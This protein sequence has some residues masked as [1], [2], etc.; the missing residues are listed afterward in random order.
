MN[1]TGLQC[2]GIRPE[3]ELMPAPIRLI[4]ALTPMQESTKTV[5]MSIVF[6]I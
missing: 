5:V 3:D 4:C 6:F 1:Y 2:G